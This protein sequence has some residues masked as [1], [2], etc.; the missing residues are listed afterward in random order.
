MSLGLARAPVGPAPG[1]EWNERGRELV[2][3]LVGGDF[4]T[5]HQRLAPDARQVLRVDQIAQAWTQAIG[6]AGEPGE[7]IVSRRSI[8]DDIG[9]L[10]G[11]DCSRRALRLL[12]TL[13]P[14]GEIGMLRL[15]GPGEASP[16]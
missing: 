12:M 7:F 3:A 2:N 8:G 16:W 15:L 14:G 11:V 13:T 10:A 1:P 4:E 6:H 5:V 9:V